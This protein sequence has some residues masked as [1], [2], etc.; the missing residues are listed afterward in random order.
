VIT[1]YVPPVMHD[2]LHVARCILDAA[3]G[4][5]KPVLCVFMARD[6]I[7]REVIALAGTALPIFRFPEAAVGAMGAMARY[8]AW[9]D[10][11]VDEP[12]ALDVDRERAGRA[13]A[14]AAAAGRATLT[15]EDS[16][17]VLEAYG[18]R[19]AKSRV[20]AS[21]K[22]LRARALEVGLP[23]VMKIQS[24]DIS[25]KTEVGGVVTDLRTV[26]EV[27][28]AFDGMMRRVAAKEPK[29]R[30]EGVLLQ[31]MRRGGQEMILGVTTD[32]L[33]GPLLM[34]G[35]GGVLV[36]V[37][38]DVAFRVNPVTPGDVDAMIAGLRSARLLKGFRGRPP[39]CVDAYK[40]AIL[41]LGRLVTDFAGILEVDV[42]PFMVGETAKQSLAV[43]ARIRIDPA[44]FG[45]AGG[46]VRPVRGPSTRRR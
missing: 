33:F 27:E 28:E 16:R 15:L 39:L 6:E 17:E 24:P 45:D 7:L 25:H 18:I 32:P 30:I 34:A 36:E 12:A 8:R 1:L 21:R 26:A 44:A 9:R 4:A 20:A 11:P 43:D 5:R 19:F 38:N 2:P 22:Q 46:E 14:D 42:N 13:L 3:K 41:R 29:A 23:L 10:R 40:D 31:E 37:A 35:A